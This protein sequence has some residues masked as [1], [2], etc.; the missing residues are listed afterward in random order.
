M[1]WHENGRMPKTRI[2]RCVFQKSRPHVRHKLR[3]TALHP[4]VL[5][6]WHT[7]R[8]TYFLGRLYLPWLCNACSCKC[9]VYFYSGQGLSGMDTD[10]NPLEWAFG[11]TVWYVSR[12]PIPCDTTAVYC[13]KVSVWGGGNRLICSSCSVACL[14]FLDVVSRQSPVQFQSRIV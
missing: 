3:Q 9:Y 12:S 8:H 1:F 5:S 13:C 4:Y 7:I 6:S 11:K 10:L 14:W 2:V